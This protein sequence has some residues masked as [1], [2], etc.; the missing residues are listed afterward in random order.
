VPDEYLPVALSMLYPLRHSE[1]RQPPSRF[2]K[3]RKGA[4]SGSMMMVTFS[5]ISRAA[6]F[7]PAAKR[8]QP[9]IFSDMVFDS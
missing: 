4:I 5:S 8:R 3:V 2:L 1:L 9:E 7:T 6:K